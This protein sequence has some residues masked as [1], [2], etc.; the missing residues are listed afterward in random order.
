MDPAS[1]TATQSLVGLAA[2]SAATG[3]ASAYSQYQTAQGQAKL[4]RSQDTLSLSENERDTQLELARTLAARNNLFAATGTDPT[5]GSAMASIMADKAAADRTLTGIEGRRGL[6]QSA[7]QTAMSGA[8]RSLAGGI[9]GSLLKLGTAGYAAYGAGVS[10][11]S[12]IGSTS[13]GTDY[14]GYTFGGVY[15]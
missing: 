13:Q 7:Y 5:G 6:V 3:A 15:G 2:A 10:G 14:S 8:R 12:N 4:Q 9:T 11:S 1:I